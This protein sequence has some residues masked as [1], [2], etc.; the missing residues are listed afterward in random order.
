MI[1]YQTV[2]TAMYQAMRPAATRIPPDVDAALRRALE[3]ETDPLAR[4]HLEV[5]LENARLAA[6][7][8]GLVCGDTGFPMYFEQ[9]DRSVREGLE[10]ARDQLG[11]PPDF[12]FTDVSTRNE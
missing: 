5:S 11:I 8:K 4:R 10:R 3:E 6:T 2:E 7:G 12:N 9:L 1:P